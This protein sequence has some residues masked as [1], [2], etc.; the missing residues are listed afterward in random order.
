[1]G[2]SSIKQTMSSP[3]IRKPMSMNTSRRVIVICPLGKMKQ[4]DE[5]DQKRKAALI[6]EAW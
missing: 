3:R 5:G 1:M 2:E 6:R 4:L